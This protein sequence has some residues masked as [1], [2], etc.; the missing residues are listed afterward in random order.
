M[1]QTTNNKQT[2]NSTAAFV[3]LGRKVS[4]IWMLEVTVREKRPTVVLGQMP[5]TMA[6]TTHF[7]NLAFYHCVMKA[8]LCDLVRLVVSLQ[9]IAQLQ[10][11]GGGHKARRLVIAARCR[12][13]MRRIV[14]RF[15][16]Q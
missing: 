4:G 11:G 15:L 1:P 2:R 10:P 14:A 7:P 8:D 6:C 12:R 13:A 16:L 5:C 9:V 3:R